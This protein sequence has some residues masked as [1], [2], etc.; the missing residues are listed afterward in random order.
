VEAL[1]ATN[2]SKHYT[3]H[4]ALRNINFSIPDRSIVGL[5]GPNGAGKTT[6]I[7]IINQI[8]TP[9]TGQISFYGEDL[10][11]RHISMIGYLPEERGLYKKMKVGDQLTYLARLRG[12]TKKE[13][14]EKSKAWVKKFEIADWWNKKVEDLSKGMAQKIQFIS[15]ILHRP[16]LIILDE[17]FSGFDPI[18]ARLITEE[19][20][21]LREQ[22]STVVFSTHR[23][24]TVEAL[25][26]HILLINN[27]EIILEGA[28]SR[29]RSQFRSDTYEVRH[30]GA[31]ETTGTPYTLLSREQVEGELFHSTLKSPRD[32]NPNRILQ[33][34]IGV[35]EVHSFIE[36]LP[37]M[38]DIFISLV[39][40]GDRE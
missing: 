27:A 40:G 13:A 17:P 8:I 9:D 30:V 39:K 28:K 35:T 1:V 15:T 4:T 22:G 6:L 26:D 25:C 33:F 34:L 32:E 5:L 18:N 10:A 21:A 31:F 19:I 14:I 29:I 7:R 3:Q 12:M 38:S 2:I 16:R 24:E 36:K 37:T 23:M 20:L 11:P